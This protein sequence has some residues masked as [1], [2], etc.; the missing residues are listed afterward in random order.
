MSCANN[1]GRENS[2]IHPGRAE[3][4]TLRRKKIRI[5]R[6]S[7]RGKKSKTGQQRKIRPAWGACLTSETH[8]PRSR[9]KSQKLILMH[10]TNP[11]VKHRS[12]SE[13]KIGTHLQ[14]LR[15]RG[16][17]AAAAAIRQNRRRFVS[18]VVADTDT[19]KKRTHE[20]V[21][22]R[23]KPHRLRLCRVSVE[24]VAD[25]ATRFQPAPLVSYSGPWGPAQ[26]KKGAACLF[27]THQKGT[28]VTVSTPAPET[29]KSH[30]VVAFFVRWAGL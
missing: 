11:R 27:L 21:G 2:K 5:E 17:P 1:G 18:A 28:H 16:K 20:D 3:F 4:F 8:P 7:A 29:K 14:P 19:N 26:S 23:R 9:Q 10:M 15:I 12:N 25:A 24:H 30:L 13:N 22:H 6:K